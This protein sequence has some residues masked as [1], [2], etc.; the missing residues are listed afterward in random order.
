MDVVT[1]TECNENVV[2]AYFASSIIEKL[3]R[4]VH[5]K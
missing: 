5:M 1:V 2:D 3:V 4:S